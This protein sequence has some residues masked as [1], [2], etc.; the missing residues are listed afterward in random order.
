[1]FCQRIGQFT[2]HVSNNSHICP[3]TRQMLSI[4]IERIRANSRLILTMTTIIIHKFFVNVQIHNIL[5]KLI[6][7]HLCKLYAKKIYISISSYKMWS[8][9]NSFK[10]N[11][12]QIKF[13]NYLNKPTCKICR[14]C[15]T[16]IQTPKKT[17]DTRQKLQPWPLSTINISHILIM[18]HGF[19]VYRTKTLCRKK[20]LQNF[21]TLRKQFFF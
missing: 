2:S 9:H 18:A 14:Q 7:F 21:E 11:T 8:C 5:H 1:M 20:L 12:H 4:N 15:S 16:L 13:I 6:Q 17:H 10:S 19:K 3:N